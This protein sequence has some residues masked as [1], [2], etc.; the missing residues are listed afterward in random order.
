MRIETHERHLLAR[1]LAAISH[2][3]T[4]RRRLATSGIERHHVRRAIE[5]GRWMPL[6]HQAI[7]VL[8]ASWHPVLSPVVAATFNAGTGAWA[9]GES[10]LLLAGLTGWQ[11]QQIH[12]AHSISTGRRSVPG[13]RVH[14]L[15][16]TP[17][18][19]EQP[20]R[21][22]HPDMAALRAAAWANSDRQAAAL[23]AM[24][25]QQRLTHPSRLREA[26]TQMPKLRRRALIVGLIADIAGGAE[27]MGEIDFARE[28]RRRGIPAPERQVLRRTQRGTYHLDVL[29][30]G[31]ELVVEINGA[32]HYAG[33]N[34][35]RDA[36][37]ANE[38]SMAG[39]TVLT[40]PR[41]ALRVDPEP[42]FA[43]IGRFLNHSP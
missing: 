4:S 43:Q 28:C 30:P 27:S 9:D 26:L 38:L 21:R 11:S 34:P 15:E 36:L 10:A 20:V 1:E 25:V 37:R 41:I 39:A 31:D 33:D 29:W 18:L 7:R 5:A 32:H 8:D 17:R 22:A 3:V 13:A 2:G 14:R 42:F 16:T 35:T 40:I 6:G 23:L 19:L 24:S 12:L